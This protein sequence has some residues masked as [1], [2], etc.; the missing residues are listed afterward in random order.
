MRFI[1]TTLIVIFLGLSAKAQSPIF[2]F[3][4]FSNAN[5]TGDSCD[6][7][8]GTSFQS[9]SFNGLMVYRLGVFNRWIDEPYL[10]RLRPGNSVEF[11]EQIGTNPDRITIPLN[12]T[13]FSTI[14]G[15]IDSTFCAGANVDFSFFA[16][17]SL[18]T[19]AINYLDTIKIVGR[20][21]TTVFF[22]TL[23]QKYI[24]T[25]PASS[26]GTNLSFTGT[27]SP[28]TLNSST[29]T[30]VN[31]VA[32]TSISLTATGTDL[33]ITN[34]APNINQTISTTGAAGNITL[35]NGGGTLNLNVNDADANPT[36]EIQ[37]LSYAAP[38]LSLS[39]GGGS[40]SI[41]QGDITGT[42]ANTR[43]AYFTGAKT[44][45]GSGN[46]LY[47]GNG[48]NIFGHRFINSGTIIPYAD[49]NDLS[50][51]ARNNFHMYTLVA[52]GQ[53]VFTVTAAGKFGVNKY[54]P[55]DYFHILS[56]DLNTY[57]TGETTQFGS[58][59]S[60]AT[61]GFKFIGG[62]AYQLGEITMQSRLAN[63]LEGLMQ[64]K[65]RTAAGSLVTAMAIT[66]DNVGIGT[67]SPAAKLHVVGAA[68]ITGSAGTGTSI[69]LRT[70]SGDISN[71]TL[72]AGLSLSGGTLSSTATG[73]V[74]GTGIANKV[75]YWSGTNAITATNNFAFDGTNLSVGTAT[76]GAGRLNV[77]GNSTS[78]GLQVNAGTLP[79]FGSTIQTTATAAAGETIYGL[80]MTGNTTGITTT[81]YL[82][83]LE[84]SGTGSTIL[85]VNTA[86][87]GGDP[88]VQYNLVGATT[89]WIHGID[90]SSEGNSF[91][92]QPFAQLGGGATGLSITTD[93][94]FGINKEAPLA[95]I[96]M[97][98]TTDGIA[99]SSG[100][101]A[102][103]PTSALRWLRYNS[104]M[105][106][107]ETR[108]ASANWH[109]INSSQS[110]SLTA[111]GALGTTPTITVNNGAE[112]AYTVTLLVGTAPTANAVIYTRTFPSTWSV[113]PTV[114]F[115]A[116]NQLTASEI[117]KF[118][119]DT[120][121]TGSYTIRA[122]G[123]LT[124]GQTY[125]LNVIIRN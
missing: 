90:N 115:S 11:I 97:D 12:Q 89:K 104:S 77:T 60:P 113:A 96:D 105:F 50:I 55:V 122:N 121:T 125:K 114:V 99:L 18:R 65:S 62:G 22:D 14:S 120:Q 58:N 80:D 16:S 102:N 56:N 10:I 17:D 15:F 112:M 7:C 79:S 59:A 111:G 35:S 26:G 5:M 41:P 74:T 2:E 110:V 72:G 38:N 75:A 84:N 44:I 82:H 88:A 70:A 83:R 39:G 108:T 20:G 85:Q 61:V 94:K 34:T 86:A 93:G 3:E 107:L 78:V 117:T 87:A 8:V 4:C 49:T 13:G 30:D 24:I 28:V 36:N 76:P 123:T 31:F 71:A 27:S 32:G 100:N 25:S 116:A 64:F 48:L 21:G 42:G 81:N 69:M 19:T 47:D 23:T 68:R 124:A 51:V 101:T 106:G 66:G 109:V 91:K 45:T 54:N 73:T 43:L 92:L 98:N 57:I 46:A 95:S 33:T 53:P 6:I 40:V 29:G 67:V 1:V 118:Y 37:T 52:P 63:V 9:R 119:V 103:R